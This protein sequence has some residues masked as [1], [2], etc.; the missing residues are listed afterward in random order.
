MKR[1]IRTNIKTENMKGM[2]FSVF[3]ATSLLVACNTNDGEHNNTDTITTTNITDPVENAEA[4]NDN[5]PDSVEDDADYLTDAAHG[6]LKEVAMAQVAMKKAQSAEI[7]KLAQMILSDHKA[8]NEKVKALAKQKNI[9]L[10]DSLPTNERDEI[11]NNDKK[12]SDFDKDY[13]EEMV[14]DHEKDIDNFKKASDNA[15]DADVKKLFADALPKLQHHLEMA[16]ATKDK[17][18]K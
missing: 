16:K 7:R 18:K 13:A 3:A 10:P 12:G 14:E 17:L 15:K 5:L 11:M 1:K 9:A 4:K 2:L 6:G 8:L